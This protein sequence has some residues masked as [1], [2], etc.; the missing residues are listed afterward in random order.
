MQ[1]IYNFIYQLLTP[2][3]WVLA[4]V[5]NIFH[6]VFVN[7]F[8][9]PE[10]GAS[11]ILSV[12]FLT[13]FVQACIFPVF[14]KQMKS[15]RKMQ[16]IQPQII[17]IQNK[18]KGKN[19]PAS[20]EA[21]SRE[22]MKLYQDNHVN[23]MGSCAPS[24]VQMFVFMSLYYVLMVVGQISSGVRK[25]AFGPITLD[26]AHQFEQSSFFGL[27]L[28]Q[29]F[30]GSNLGSFV[31]STAADTLGKAILVVCIIYMCFSLF[32]MQYY[33]FRRNTPTAMQ[34]T[35]Q[36]KM[37]KSMM[38]IFPIM[39]IFSG[40]TLPFAFLLYWMTNN[41]CNM[42][43][44]IWQVR[45][46][47]TP[48]SPAAE[49]KKVRDHDRENARRAKAGQPSLEDEAIEKAKEE[50]EQRAK[51]SYQREQPKRKRKAKK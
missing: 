45:H 32:Y 26:V 37:Q 39:Y 44:S 29:S 3:E 43:R 28:S 24:L 23:P 11:W 12:I 27:K 33:N 4:W 49:D 8:Q 2:I 17:K 13:I 25:D 16:G 20:R 22:T 10:V 19:D 31:Q 7:V 35:Q 41:T 6:W 38:Y 50:A 46:F 21:M 51:T 1:G 47:P 15:M 30:F 42:L 34:G 40:A 18:Y 5:M 9:M 14:Y 36:M 48:G